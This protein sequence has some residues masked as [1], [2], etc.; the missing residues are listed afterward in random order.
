MQG[1]NM[2][3]LTADIVAA[4]VAN[5]SVAI[6]EVGTLVRKVHEALAKL[7]KGPVEQTPEEKVPLVSIRASVKPDHI[8]CMECGKKQKTLRRHLHAAHG[9]TPEQYRKD[10]GLPDSYPMTAP[11]YSEQR[12][13]MAKRIGLGQKA[14]V[15]EPTSQAPKR[16]RRK[17]RATAGSP[18]RELAP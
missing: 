7:D 2:I 18:S 14:A 6:G 10:Y 16:T 9:M 11:N 17:S 12:R 15:P 3:A 8:V 5:N 4:H 13:T 1:D